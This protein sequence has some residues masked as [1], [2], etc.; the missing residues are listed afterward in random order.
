M[1]KPGFKGESKNLVKAENVFRR[2]FYE[3]MNTNKD[4]TSNTAAVASI[5]K[6]S[7]FQYLIHTMGG[8]TV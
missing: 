4:F 5:S 7:N 3:Q 1:Q 8:W 2:N 6:H